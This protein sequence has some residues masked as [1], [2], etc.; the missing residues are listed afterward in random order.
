MR[1]VCTPH[2]GFRQRKQSLVRYARFDG[3]QQIRTTPRT[4]PTPATGE[5]PV[6]VTACGLCGSELRVWRTGWPVT[7]GHEIAGV[8]EQ[9]GHAL[10]GQRVVAYIPV[11]CGTCNACAN[12]DTHLCERATERVGWQRDGGHA[13]FVVIPTQCALLVPDDIDDVLAPWL[14]DTIGTPAHGIRLARKL[15]QQGPVAIIGAGPIGLGAVLAAP[16]IGFPDRY[17][18]DRKAH[19]PHA[20]LAFGA[21]DLD[22]A[23]APRR[24]PLVLKTAGVNA[25]RQRA[26]E[27]TAPGGVCVYLGESDRWEI[28]EV[29][30][31]RRKD[32]F[33]ARSFYFPLHEYALTIELL[34][35]DRDNYRQLVNARV[36]RAG[37]HD[38]FA[39]FATGDRLQPQCTPAV[40]VAATP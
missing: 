20:A 16:P 29:T 13:E 6:R 38:L 28:D 19:R 37:L 5:V 31:I 12:G 23:T 35:T 30:A 3:P 33:I 34:R 14:L 24:F 11:W 2:I 18:T 4:R 17:I 9:P 40:D 39:A 10:H 1:A 22:A 32:F 36:S 15:V 21:R 25:A 7:P 27:R 26:L 8:V